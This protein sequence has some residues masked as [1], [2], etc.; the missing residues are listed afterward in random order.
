VI[1]VEN[2]AKERKGRK[3]RRRE[4]GKEGRQE[5]MFLPSSYCSFSLRPFFVATH[6]L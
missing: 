6:F 1:N 4:G 2:E 3:E 5:G